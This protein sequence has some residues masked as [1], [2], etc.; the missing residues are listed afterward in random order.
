MTHI[1]VYKVLDAP[2]IPARKLHH[3]ALQASLS[4]IATGG[5][6]SRTGRG[7]VISTDPRGQPLLGDI[8]EDVAIYGG[9]E[10]V[11]EALLLAIGGS[12]DGIDTLGELGLVEAAWRAR[13]SSR[14]RGMGMRKGE[15][16][17]DSIEERP[18]GGDGG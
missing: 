7:L 15:R 11:M 14:L 2:A 9:D 3:I 4:S 8:S 13:V 16:N 5:F 10:R 6:R 17:A 18:G 1:I 12:E